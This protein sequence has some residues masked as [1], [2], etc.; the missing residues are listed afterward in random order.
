MVMLL[1][2]YLVSSVLIGIVDLITMGS[3]ERYRATIPMGDLM[4]H[5][6]QSVIGIHNVIFLPSL[7]IIGIWIAI[8]RVINLFI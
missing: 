4:F 7:V 3:Q 1:W 5:P 6:R 2:I 8:V